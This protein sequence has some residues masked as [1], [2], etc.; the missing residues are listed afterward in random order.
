ME[1][2]LHAGQ[3]NIAWPY[4]WRKPKTGDIVLLRDP[5]DNRLVIKRITEITPAGEFFVR[6]DNPNAS[7]DS[8]QFGSITK[9]L[10]CGWIER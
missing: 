3:H 10:I 2:T 9:E 1:P 4:L 6:G 7:T 5:R 8:R